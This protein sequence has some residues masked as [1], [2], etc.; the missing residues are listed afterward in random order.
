MEM[1][2]SEYTKRLRLEV[3]K[4]AFGNDHITPS[5]HYCRRISQAIKDQVGEVL[6]QDTIRNFLSGNN[7]PQIRVRDIYCTYVLGGGKDSLK[8][9]DDFIQWVE[10]QQ[11]ALPLSQDEELLKATNNNRWRLIRVAKGFGVALFA[12]ILVLV[13]IAGFSF[14]RKMQQTTLLEY[15]FTH[16]NLKKLEAD[17]WFLFPDSV[18][19]ALWGRYPN[20]GYLTLETFPGDSYLANRDYT[21]FVKNIL[22]HD[23]HC[24]ACCE[25]AVKIVG[26]SPQQRYQQAGFFL[27]YND[28]VVPSFRLTYGFSAYWITTEAFIR[29]DTYSNESFIPITYLERIT[30]LSEQEIAAGIHLDSVVLKLQIQDGQYF[31]MHKINNG[32]FIPLDSKAMDLPPPCYIGLAA[33]QGRPEIPYPVFPQADT[34]PVNFE[35]V[36][37]QPCSD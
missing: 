5:T 16:S 8:L 15:R 10:N 1:Q 9:F 37:I 31:L 13:C 4:R 18:D 27:F 20:S 26:F 6:H 2:E 34:I 25:I 17:G 19:L 14:F 36:R 11:G 22:A 7:E 12:G 29:N 3:W 28:K 32:A 23:F 24:G 33:F 35:Y 30:V 21:P